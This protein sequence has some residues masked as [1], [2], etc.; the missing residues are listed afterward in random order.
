MTRPAEVLAAPVGLM[1]RDSLN[2]ME[3]NLPSNYPG[4]VE[5][6]TGDQGCQG[7]DQLISSIDDPVI[8]SL[9][10]MHAIDPGYLGVEIP[11]RF[12]K[13]MPNTRRILGKL[14]VPMAIVGYTGTR[15]YHE[16]MSGNPGEA[17]KNLMYGLGGVMMYAANMSKSPRSP[18]QP[19]HKLVHRRLADFLSGK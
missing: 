9:L 4:V 10:T 14:G 2:S 8:I 7:L 11:E 12:G 13:D 16:A 5:Y 6:I 3:E 17:A 1:L 15:A 18:L 19:K